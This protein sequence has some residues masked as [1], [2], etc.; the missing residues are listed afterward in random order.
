[1]TFHRI[2]MTMTVDEKLLNYDEKVQF[3][4]QASNDPRTTMTIRS[5]YKREMNILLLVSNKLRMT[6][7]MM[8]RLK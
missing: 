7:M 1:M 5:F 6:T 4:N 2:R 8:R 3:N